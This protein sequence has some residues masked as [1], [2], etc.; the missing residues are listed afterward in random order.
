ML[1]EG[2]EDG[3]LGRVLGRVAILLELPVCLPAAEEHA[4]DVTWFSPL[5]PLPSPATFN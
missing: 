3:L 5:D 2:E 1:G 4:H